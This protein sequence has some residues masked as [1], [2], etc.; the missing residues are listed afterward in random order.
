MPACNVYLPKDMPGGGGGVSL[1]DVQDLL[2]SYCPRCSNRL[3]FS[4]LTPAQV[5]TLISVLN[6]AGLTGG[7]GGTPFDITNLTTTQLTSLA[8]NLGP[9]LQTLIG[10]ISADPGQMLRLGTDGKVLFVWNDLR[11]AAQIT[12]YSIQD[13]FG[14]PTGAYAI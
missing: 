9:Y 2:N 13:A 5:T 14:N 7:T 3:D 8:T 11:T 10:G 12:G 6:A 1:Q 4:Q